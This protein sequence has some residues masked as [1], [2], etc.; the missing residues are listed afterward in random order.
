MMKI[1][2]IHKGL[3]LPQVPCPCPRSGQS[4]NGWP[5]GTCEPGPLCHQCDPVEPGCHSPA[6]VEELKVNGEGREG[7]G[8]GEWTRGEG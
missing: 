4:G 6:A 2:S 5:H 7:E 1:N 8:G 3:T